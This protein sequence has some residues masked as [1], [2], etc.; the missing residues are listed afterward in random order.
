MG[1]FG[2]KKARDKLLG[3][4]T[5]YSIQAMTSYLKSRKQYED[6]LTIFDAEGIDNNVNL[7]SETIYLMGVYD[8]LIRCLDNKYEILEIK[9]AVGLLNAEMLSRDEFQGY[10]TWLEHALKEGEYVHGSY[11]IKDK[12][13]KLLDVLFIAGQLSF[14][15]F[16]TKEDGLVPD[17][18]GLEDGYDFYDFKE[19]VELK[20][21]FNNGLDI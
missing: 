14:I 16:H 8:S 7:L 17:T 18:L 19:F 20:E 3:V 5:N 6:R 1:L 13:I 10:Q 15:K 12:K 21:R 2:N 4:A 9:D 11:Q